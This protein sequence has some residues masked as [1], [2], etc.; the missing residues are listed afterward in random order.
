MAV[1]RR[2]KIF[3]AATAALTAPITAVT[4][5]TATKTMLQLKPTTNVAIISWGYE[6]DVTPT[7]FVRTELISTGTVAATVTAF[8][9]GDVIKY[10]DAAQSASAASLGTTASG[11]T[12][13]AEGTITA[14]RVLD[15]G[16]GWAQSYVIQFPLD[17]EP[18][19]IANDL[20]RVRM[21][22]AT[23]INAITWI[24]YEE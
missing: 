15:M 1:R 8:N 4:T 24:D 22:T 13:T 19:V 5:G 2:Y 16:P 20:L 18:G 14:T 9:A 17:R 23:A 10:D 3:N 7:A 21:T 12:A 11:F 6:F